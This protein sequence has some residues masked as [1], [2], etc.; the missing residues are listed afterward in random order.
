M[1]TPI[2]LFF[3]LVL[4]EEVIASEQGE[5]VWKRQV[6]HL[7][8]LNTVWVEDPCLIENSLKWVIG[9]DT[10]PAQ[11]ERTSLGSRFGV[12]VQFPAVQLTDSQTVELIWLSFNIP[13]PW[14]R[15]S[16]YAFAYPDSSPPSTDTA[17]LRWSPSSS[18]LTN[19]QSRG[20]KKRGY[21]SRGIRWGSEGGSQTEAGLHLELSGEIVPNIVVEG[22]ID[23]RQLGSVALPSGSSTTF[24]ELDRIY[25]QVNTPATQSVVGDYD[26]DWRVGWWGPVERRLRGLKAKWE[27]NGFM[28]QGA[29]STG[30][31]SLRVQTLTLRPLDQGP[32]FLTDPYGNRVQVVSGSEKVW[33]NGKLLQRGPQGEYKVDY[34]QG[35]ITFLP[36]LPIGG[37]ERVEVEFEYSLDSYPQLFYGFYTSRFL[38]SSPFRWGISWLE[39]GSQ[40][41]APIGWSWRED[42]RA[43]VEEAGDDARRARVSAVDSVGWGGGDYIWVDSLHRQ[44]RFSPPDSTGKPTGY[45]RVNFSPRPQGSYTRR[46]DP[47]WN[48]YFFEYAGEGR[49][50]WDPVITLPLPGKQ[51]WGWG[52]LGWEGKRAIGSINIG[53]SDRDF[54]TLSPL[55]DG[56]NRG[57]GVQFQNTLLGLDQRLQ[58]TIEGAWTS[59]HFQPPYRNYGQDDRYR[60]GMD[61]LQSGGERRWEGLLQYRISPILSMSAG[62]G[63]RTQIGGQGSSRYELGGKGE[64]ERFQWN[65]KYQALFLDGEEDF[66]QA[67]IRRW[68]GVARYRWSQYFTE[69][70]LY[71]EERK[72]NSPV[73][74]SSHL[75]RGIWAWGR[76]LQ[77]ESWRLGIMGR[78]EADA[79][80]P[81]PLL[82]LG[83]MGQWIAVRK[84]GQWDIAYFY[85][86]RLSD[87]AL[88]QRESVGLRLNGSWKLIPDLANLEGYYLLQSG[89]QPGRVWLARYV[90]AQGGGWKREGDQWVPDPKGD[91]ELSLFPDSDPSFS[92]L[93]NS[94]W[95]LRLQPAQPS[96]LPGFG[97]SLR[98]VRSTTRW[99]W[100]GTSRNLSF[101]RSALPFPQSEFTKG[102]ELWRE[103]LLL[104]SP[105]GKADV[106]VVGEVERLWGGWSLGGEKVER[107]HY[108]M[109][110]QRPFSDRATLQVMPL[111][112]RM[113]R[114]SEVGIG[115]NRDTRSLGGQVQTM[116]TI[117][118]VAWSIKW[119][120]EGRWQAEGKGRAREARLTGGVSSGSAIGTTLAE[121][122]WRYLTLT[123]APYLYDLTQGWVPGHNW[124]LSLR[125]QLNLPH[126]TNLTGDLSAL[127]RGRSAPQWYGTLEVRVNL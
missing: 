74:L 24:G 5:V 127:W 68:E 9:G 116:L 22:V 31:T 84:K 86:R 18:P 118:P 20:M 83:Y 77:Q 36:L 16:L 73:P 10:F 117:K 7:D 106:R 79:S 87:D 69:S 112:S 48:L 76:M 57:S 92:N 32:Y 55:D 125:S 70:Q 94:Q 108:Q 17:S 21:I 15:W 82:A 13:P 113:M 49:G 63:R 51:R 26:L 41:E 66:H 109:T 46:Y 12:R 34:L 61:S 52:S 99:E 38:P 78:Q 65:G 105:E 11:G 54:N 62:M 100:E 19:G 33:L 120:Y 67:E 104:S 80:A 95:S 81:H 42:W 50:D 71:Y 37:D 101:L 27:K 85:W 6:P 107:Q 30:N 44:L 45:L 122:T 39:E 110:W 29:V 4:F 121:A 72:I 35:S 115:V 59:P 14:L 43:A 53:L 93:L 97:R 124:Q 56:D 23:D 111:Y 8:S 2:L 98:W 58:L 64:S 47:Y 96:F 1:T 91:F 90:G 88:S 60:W 114:W 123:D 103:D 28:V 119:G 89:S 102:R 25:L 40:E 75:T 3:V 126:G